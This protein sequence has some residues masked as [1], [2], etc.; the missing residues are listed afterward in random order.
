MKPIAAQHR[1]EQMMGLAALN[2]SYERLNHCDES[3][4]RPHAIESAFTMPCL[5]CDRP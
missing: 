4:E 1:T 5:D 2:P 3:P